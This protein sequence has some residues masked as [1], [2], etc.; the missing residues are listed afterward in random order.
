MTKFL[1]GLDTPWIEVNWLHAD[2]VDEMREAIISNKRKFCTVYEA[3]Q[4]LRLHPDTIR[5][6]IKK[7]EIQAFRL[8]SGEWQIPIEEIDNYWQKGQR[9]QF[10]GFFPSDSSP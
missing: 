9:S 3:V 7:G 2:Y 8:D 10:G 5:F 1:D 6:A 4:I